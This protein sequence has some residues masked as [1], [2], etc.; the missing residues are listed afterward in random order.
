MSDSFCDPMDCSHQSPLSMGF[1][2]QE[3]WSGLLYLPPGDLSNPGIEAVS[4]SLQ[5][6]FF[7]LTAEPF[8]SRVIV[9]AI[10]EVE[11]KSLGWAL[12]QHDWL[13]KIER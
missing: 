3:H 12:N 13:C 10:R 11:M 4:P 8:G 5:A 7:F 2:S 9:R 1:P 6:F